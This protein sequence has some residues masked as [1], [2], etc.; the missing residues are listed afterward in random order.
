MTRMFPN[1]PAVVQETTT[2][3]R[4]L[5]GA[6]VYVLAFM[7]QEREKHHPM[8]LSVAAAIENLLLAAWEKGIGSCWI[9]TVHDAGFSEQLQKAYAPDKGEFISLITL[10]YPE[11]VPK[12]PARK[13]E[14]WEIR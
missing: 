7:D 5:G 6:P 3:L 11:H 8:I 4:S 9:T 10:G 14:R 1:H 12:A 2:F 13:Q